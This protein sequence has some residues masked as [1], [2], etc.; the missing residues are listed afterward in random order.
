MGQLRDHILTEG[1]IRDLVRMLDEELDGVA[2]EQRERLE[3]IEQRLVDVRQRL[4]RSWHL[5]E[6]TDI[7]MSDASDRIKEH[8]ERQEQLELAA[9][10]AR[11]VLA[12]R[13]V[14]LDSA[15]TIASFASDMSEF[16]RTSELTETRTFV[17]SFVKQITVKPGQAVIHYTIPTPEDS[18]I[19]SADAA[20]VAFSQRVMS[21]VHVG[22]PTGTVLRTFEFVVALEPGPTREVAGAAECISTPLAGQE[23]HVRQVERVRQGQHRVSATGVHGGA[24]PLAA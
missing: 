8:R 2:R 4:S 22:R 14:L 24:R 1:N 7:D 11:A 19:G 15:D 13:R 5:I 18:P 16:L 20:E 6:M 23:R 9:E 21:T 17:R 12:E 3:T 10:E